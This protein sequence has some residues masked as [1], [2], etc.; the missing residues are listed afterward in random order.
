MKSEGSIWRKWDLH[1]HTPA[2]FEWHGSNK[3]N[4]LSS[5]EQEAIW[6]IV[7]DKIN[8]LDIDV[9]CVMDYWTLDGYI[10]LRKYINQHTGATT[11]RIFP[12]IEL[13]LEAPT[14]FRLNTHVLFD[15]SLDFD[16][17]AY[18]IARLKMGGPNGS[19]PSRRNF[20]EVGKSY[21]DGKLRVHG[22]K[23]QDR[24][25]DDKMYDI[26]V[27]TALI[28]RESLVE[29]ISL[30]GD[31]HCLV[32][33]PYDT[34][35][36]LED[37][38]WKKH[39]YDDSYLMKLADI[40]E[41]RDAAAVDLFLGLGLANKPS[42]GPD[43]VHNLGGYPKPVVSGSDAHQVSNYGDYPSGRITWLKAQPTFSGLRQVCFEPALRCFI[44]SK[45][46]QRRLYNPQS[47]V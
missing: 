33:Q 38:D 42:V 44:G 26:G 19:P 34:S 37:L 7:I 6:A 15:D 14:N 40:F 2:S 36:G 9:F 47:S 12:G 16:T 43:F 8:G 35:D 30:V 5:D 10:S 20:I 46:C 3:L 45:P 22:C 1:I 41:T 4:E 23:P 24:D 11:K 21:D 27:K 32:I 29:A 28:T 17:L 18:F 39:P 13:R 31:E 25:D